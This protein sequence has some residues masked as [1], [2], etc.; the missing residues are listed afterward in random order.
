MTITSVLNNRIG[1]TLNT[2]GLNYR[3]QE[4]ANKAN[5]YRQIVKNYTILTISLSSVWQGNAQNKFAATYQNAL[6]IIGRL[7]DLCDMAADAMKE[8]T[9]SVSTADRHAASKI[10]SC[11]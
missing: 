3:A 9:N 4:V 7:A 6:P 10:R 5:D 8:Y 11:F 2:D 1:F